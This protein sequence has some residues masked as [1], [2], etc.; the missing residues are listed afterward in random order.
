MVATEA[1]VDLLC[2][3][4]RKA[5]KLCFY[6]PGN[7]PFAPPAQGRVYATELFDKLLPAVYGE[8]D[9]VLA[10]VGYGCMLLPALRHRFIADLN[11]LNMPIDVLDGDAG[12]GKS[13]C[14]I[15]IGEAN[16]KP[17]EA[18]VQGELQACYHR[19]AVDGF[20]AS[21]CG[22]ICPA[23]RFSELALDNFCQH[24][25]MSTCTSSC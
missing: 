17:R 21:N 6:P 22:S 20:H 10:A 24:V 2:S 18:L 3:K 7:W 14:L 5:G 25:H 23:C 11:M 4:E 12:T 9:W 19:R 16:G 13:T 8:Q 1:Q 15:I